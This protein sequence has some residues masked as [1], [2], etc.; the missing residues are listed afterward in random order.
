MN[1]EVELAILK[2]QVKMLESRLNFS[3]PKKPVIGFPQMVF[4]LVSAE[5]GVEEEEILSARQSA[6]LVEPRS[7]VAYL[8]RMHTNLSLPQI[9]KRMGRHH[10]TIIYAIN[11]TARNLLS[12]RKLKWRVE[13]VE[14]NLGVYFNPEQYRSE[15]NGLRTTAV[16]AEYP[17]SLEDGR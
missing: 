10:T 3:A 8:L 13:H 12:N 2:R 15:N 6:S 1:V 17:E 7:V 9:G 14:K 5:W 16:S 11:K 4:M